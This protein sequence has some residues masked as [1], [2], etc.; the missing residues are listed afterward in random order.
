M[1]YVRGIRAVLGAFRKSDDSS[2]ITV[3][4]VEKFGDTLSS[5]KSGKTC[6]HG[7]N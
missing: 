6:E 7:D 2:S 1:W 3:P 4:P 5:Q